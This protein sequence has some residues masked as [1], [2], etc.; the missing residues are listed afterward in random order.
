MWLCLWAGDGSRAQRRRNISSETA[1]MI[2]IWKI[3]LDQNGDEK[4]KMPATTTKE[5]SDIDDGIG[6]QNSITMSK[7]MHYTPASSAS[8]SWKCLFD[9]RRFHHHLF[10]PFARH[11]VSSALSSFAYFLR[12]SVFCDF[13]SLL[14]AAA[15][16]CA[17]RSPLANRTH[18]HSLTSHII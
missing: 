18:M 1:F 10:G 6:G 9:V 2:H 11:V 14:A 15:A 5:Y 4:K 12:C 7:S 3:F 8:A 13:F 16:V 17:I